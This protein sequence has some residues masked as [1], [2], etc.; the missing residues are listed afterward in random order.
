MDKSSEVAISLI[1]DLLQ[2]IIPV[3]DF[4]ARYEQ[5][6]NF[7]WAGRDQVPAADQFARLFNVVA[8]YSPYPDERDLIPNYT[9][10]EQVLAVARDVRAAAGA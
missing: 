5:H 3:K 8:W 10:E 4:C 1:D 9:S 2:G 6:W 7:Y